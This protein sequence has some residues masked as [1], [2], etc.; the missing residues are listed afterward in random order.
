[1]K[2]NII[3]NK[4]NIKNYS[5]LLDYI[6]L[7]SED[8]TSTIIKYP[9]EFMNIRDH[10][11]EWELNVPIFVTAFYLFVITY[12]RI[13][14]QNEF[15]RC[16]KFIN[17]KFFDAVKL[18]DERELALKA[19]TYRAYPS[20]VRDLHFNKLVSEQIKGCDII[21]NSALDIDEGIDLLISNSNG[22]YA[23][24]LYTKTNRALQ[25]RPKK[26]KKHNEYE[27]VRY[28]EFPVEFKGSLHVGDFFLYGN[29][30]V[31]ELKKIMHLIRNQPSKDA[32]NITIA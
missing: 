22:I 5:N 16:Y 13:P 26:R 28:I 1:M 21:Y 25:T 24:N 18:S 3:N 27:N 15:Y 29:K 12:Q 7:T 23:I 17:K 32:T 4:L 11:I 8:I 30:E 6:N 31:E 14:T 2:N 19:R 9:L 20:L 10:Y